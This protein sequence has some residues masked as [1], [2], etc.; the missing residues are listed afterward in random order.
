VWRTSV[1][2]GGFVAGEARILPFIGTL[3]VHAASLSRGEG[4]VTTDESPEWT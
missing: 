3:T 2:G 1:D 4:C